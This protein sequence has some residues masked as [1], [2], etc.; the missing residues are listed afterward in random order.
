[1]SIVQTSRNEESESFLNSHGLKVNYFNVFISEF[2][3]CHISDNHDMPCDLETFTRLKGLPIGELTIRNFSSRPFD[4]THGTIP[5][6]TSKRIIH[7]VK[8]IDSLIDLS[9][10]LA[11]SIGTLVLEGKSRVL[12]CTNLN[13]KLV[14]GYLSLYGPVMFDSISEFTHNLFSFVGVFDYGRTDA[15]GLVPAQ[16]KYL[17]NLNAAKISMPPLKAMDHLRRG[18]KGIDVYVSS[19]K[20]IDDAISLYKHHTLSL[21]HARLFVSVSTNELGLLF[22]NRLA[23][24]EP[25]V[26]QSRLQESEEDAIS[27]RPVTMEQGY[28]SI[29]YLIYSYLALDYSRGSPRDNRWIAASISLAQYEAE[30][31]EDHAALRFSSMA[32]TDKKRDEPPVHINIVVT[33]PL[34]S[35]A[36]LTSPIQT[37]KQQTRRTQEESIETILAR[38]KEN[39]PTMHSSNLDER[40]GV[41]IRFRVYG[42]KEFEGHFSNATSLGA[43]CAFVSSTMYERGMIQTARDFDYNMRIIRQIGIRKKVIF[44]AKDEF[45]TALH[46]LGIKDGDTIFVSKNE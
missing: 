13:E 18:M 26:D 7:R 2:G 30:E 16:T 32:I 5:M 37:W 36:M 15:L 44:L 45:R 34:Q 20:E 29:Q 23:F 6:D 21:R 33:P 19:V 35:K 9:V 17:L 46:D 41:N 39:Q 12:K 27:I 11:P 31:D 3:K 24:I 4:S 8:V 25:N 38:A 1:M 14:V 22:H 42:G 40:N 43:L 10:N 28:E